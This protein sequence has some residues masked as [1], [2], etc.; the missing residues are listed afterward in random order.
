RP[1]RGVLSP[2][3]D[4][5]ESATLTPVGHM[6]MPAKKRGGPPSSSVGRPTAALRPVKGTLT[7]VT[8]KPVKKM[9]P[10]DDED[11]E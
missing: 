11:E 7:P 5:V 1:I 4:A 9:V 10:K 2:V 6:L 8:K 3:E